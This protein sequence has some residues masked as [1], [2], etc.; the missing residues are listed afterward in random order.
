MMLSRSLQI[1]IP[2]QIQTV[3]VQTEK[4]F[5]RVVG[6]VYSVSSWLPCLVSSQLIVKSS[7]DFEK[8]YNRLTT[9]Y[10]LLIVQALSLVKML[11]HLFVYIANINS[12]EGSSTQGRYCEIVCAFEGVVHASLWSLSAYTKPH[13]GISR[14]L[15]RYAIPELLTPVDLILQQG[16]DTCPVFLS[17]LPEVGAII[18]SMGSGWWGNQFVLSQRQPRSKT[19]SGNTHQQVHLVLTSSEVFSHGRSVFFLPE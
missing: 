18:E 3:F 7:A 19:G 6:C 2:V 17:W 5:G 11:T 15:T 9:V 4:S 12:K 10:L 14:V 13:K 16:I 1:I 8:P